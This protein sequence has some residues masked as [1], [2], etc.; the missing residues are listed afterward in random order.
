MELMSV[1][2]LAFVLVPVALAIGAAIVVVGDL[3]LRTIKSAAYR[4]LPQWRRTVLW[5][6]MDWGDWRL[7]V[8]ALTLPSERVWR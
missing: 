8:R 5:V 1:M 6:A 4:L 3:S 2:F 7:L